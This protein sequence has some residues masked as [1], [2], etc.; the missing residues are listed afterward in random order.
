M[1]FQDSKNKKNQRIDY[2]TDKH[3]FKK[4]G[5]NSSFTHPAVVSETA[6]F[7]VITSEAE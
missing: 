2:C 4:S 5:T 7:N 6:L 3:P 1:R